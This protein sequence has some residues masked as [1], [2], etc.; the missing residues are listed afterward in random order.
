MRQT[1]KHTYIDWQKNRDREKKKKK[2]VK[3]NLS[4][5]LVSLHIIGSSAETR[6]ARAQDR[7]ST[8]PSLGPIHNR[9]DNR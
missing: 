5:T 8:P 7:T 2:F 6:K 4:S 9:Q 3:A 1:S